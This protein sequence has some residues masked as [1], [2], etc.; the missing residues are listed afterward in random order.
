[1][2]WQWTLVERG[3]A[4]VAAVAAAMS[5]YALVDYAVTIGAFPL[6]AA[7][8]LPLLLDGALLVAAG[9]A[10]QR[11]QDRVRHWFAS[12]AFTFFVAIS[13]AANYA[14]AVPT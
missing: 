8:G 6:V 7:L 13:A 11:S 2:A 1:M 12:L 3:G 4:A 5:Y 14:H 10:L 9:V